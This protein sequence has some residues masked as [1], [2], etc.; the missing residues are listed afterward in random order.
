MQKL[1]ARSFPYL[2]AALTLAPAAQAA[3]AEEEAEKEWQEVAL[4]LP[5][6]PEPGHLLPFYDSGSQAFALDSKSLSVAADGTVR[7][8]LVATSRSGVK[9]VSYEALRCQS[10]E[11]KLYAFGRSDGG[12]SRSRRALWEPISARDA[13]RQHSV[14]YSDYFCE[15]K[16]VAGK[17][18]LILSRMRGSKR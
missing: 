18:E 1:I 7:Y 11:R 3:V 8:T 5:E 6:A 17:T 10:Y 2:L 14:L 12:W 13:N 15:G 4:Q 9:N 16:T